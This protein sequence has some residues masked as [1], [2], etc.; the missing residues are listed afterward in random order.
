MPVTFYETFFQIWTTWTTLTFIKIEVSGKPPCENWRKLLRKLPFKEVDK[1]EHFFFFSQFFS[2]FYCY[3]RC[4]VSW[5]NFFNNPIMHLEC[6]RS[7][8]GARTYI[9]LNE[10]SNRNSEE[11][12]FSVAN[13]CRSRRSWIIKVTMWDVLQRGRNHVQF[14]L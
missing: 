7:I 12:K 5:L 3:C 11:I 1:L 6:W 8:G 2:P 4:C 13:N 10:T 9:H 14:A